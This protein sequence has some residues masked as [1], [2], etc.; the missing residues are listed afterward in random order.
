MMSLVGLLAFNFAVILPVFASKTFH[1]SGGTYGLMTTVLSVGSIAGSFSV[2]LIHH[3]ADLPRR[4][5]GRF[6]SL[7]RRHRSGP[8]HRQ[9]VHSSRRHRRGRILVRDPHLH[10]V[11]TALV[12]GV[13]RQDHG[14]VRLCVPRHHADRERALWLNQLGWWSSSRSPGRCRSMSSRRT[15]RLARAHPA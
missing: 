1:G 7:S 2:G 8:E 10:H 15:H 14:S 5:V 3:P 12:V 13:S 4:D 6:R 11:A 9:C